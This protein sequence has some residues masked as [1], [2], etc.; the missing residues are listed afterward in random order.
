[1]IAFD[2][3]AIDRCAGK[4]AVEVDDMKIFGARLGEQRACAAGSSP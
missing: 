4:G 1:M 2:R 3:L